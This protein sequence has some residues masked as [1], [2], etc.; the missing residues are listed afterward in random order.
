MEAG[1]QAVEAL[2]H[3]QPLPPALLPH[4][5]LAAAAASCRRRCCCAD[6]WGGQ[7]LLLQNGILDW[8]WARRRSRP[9]IVARRGGGPRRG[10]GKGRAE[11]VWLRRQL[12][13]RWRHVSA[14]RLAGIWSYGGAE[15]PA[16]LLHALSQAAGLQAGAE[17]VAL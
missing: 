12:G 15:A 8:Q 5:G 14:R 2:C 6:G 7:R 11:S 4:Q 9:L 16:E 1:K 3:I 10:L 17:W 13:A